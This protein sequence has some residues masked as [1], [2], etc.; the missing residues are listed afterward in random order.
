MAAD[1]IRLELSKADFFSLVQYTQSEELP[2]E[3]EPLRKILWQKL[4]KMVEHDLYSQYKTAP[5]DSQ[6]E[7]ARKRY[8]DR[9]GVPD[10]FRW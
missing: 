7:E 4:D 3:L 8:L 5:T 1:T 2:P 9:K 6:R 10:S